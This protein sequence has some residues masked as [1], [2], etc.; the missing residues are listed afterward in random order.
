MS[1]KLAAVSLLVVLVSIQP[2]CR[3]SATVPGP[4]RSSDATIPAGEENKP[5]VVGK[6][7]LPADPLAREFILRALA[8]SESRRQARRQGRTFVVGK[9]PL[10]ADPAAR[11]FLLKALALSEARRRQ[12]EASRGDASRITTPGDCAGVPYCNVM[13]SGVRRCSD[14]CQTWIHVEL[15]PEAG[16]IEH[17]CMTVSGEV[18]RCP[19]GVDC[20]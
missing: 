6:T 1:R 14:G 13:G 10:P 5:F 4:N 8:L 12:T 18:I 9:T 19:W 17:W 3:E 2:A 15:E 16:I 11:E 7:P 20:C